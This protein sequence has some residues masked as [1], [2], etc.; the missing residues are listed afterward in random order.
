MHI[1]FGIHVSNSFPPRELD[2]TDTYSEY[3][4]MPVSLAW[5]Q[6]AGGETAVYILKITKTFIACLCFFFFF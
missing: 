5:R 2:E 3:D 6:E 1:H 4:D